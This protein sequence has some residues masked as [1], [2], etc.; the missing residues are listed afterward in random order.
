MKWILKVV[1]K[2]QYKNFYLLFCIIIS[3]EQILSQQSPSKHIIQSRFLC[4][5]QQVAQRTFYR[6]LQTAKENTEKTK[7]S[8][9]NQ[10][11]R[12]CMLFPFLIYKKGYT[13]KK[14]KF[15]S[16]NTVQ[17]I[18]TLYTM[19]LEHQTV[20]SYNVHEGNGIPPT[21]GEAVF[22]LEKAQGGCYKCV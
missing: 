2:L 17:S 19:L 14:G 21:Q 8:I 18:R 6:I 15:S 11:A 22:C 12:T 10:E 9:N 1:H 16:E 7:G 5:Q 20:N 4:L 3:G 13:L